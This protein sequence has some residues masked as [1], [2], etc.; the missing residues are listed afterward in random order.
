[1]T[2][3]TIDTAKRADNADL[4]RLLEEMPMPG[5]I[6]IAYQRAP[7][8]FDALGVEGRSSQVVVGRDANGDRVIGMG[9]R[10]IKPAYV[11]GEVDDIGY[12]SGLR[13][14]PEYRRGIHLARGYKKLRELHADGQARLYLSTMLNDNSVAQRL[15]EHRARLPAYHD[16]GQL[17]HMAIAPGRL[18]PERAAARFAIRAA[19]QEDLPQVVDFLNSE[20]P[21]RQFFPAYTVED[22]TS[23]DGLLR[24]LEPSDILI[25]WDGGRIA[26]VVA[27]WNQKAYRQSVVN[28]FA[29]WFR[30]CRPLYNAGAA[31]ARLPRIPPAGSMLNYA[32][33]SLVCI[34]N[35][36]RAAFAALLAEVLRR[37]RG[38]H[39]FLIAGMHQRDP[40]LPELRKLR[41][42]S[43]LSRLY[44]VCWR[45]GEDAFS[46]L[47]ER[48]PYVETGSL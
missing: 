22:L 46:N 16:I 36:D 8:F 11:N 47:D 10:S 9:T 19:R 14:K 33:L 27:A 17:H 13:L 35:D 4:L 5:F 6:R 20:G 2:G 7:D 30:L 3:V 12:L 1:M 39:D 40:L 18:S 32:C 26:G 23:A 24:G 15:T 25:A 38:R 44:V 21:K 43:Y 41:H 48:P 42:L 31:V 28:G 37:M 34:R 29:P 45:D